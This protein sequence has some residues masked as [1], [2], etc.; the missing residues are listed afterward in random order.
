MTDLTRFKIAIIGLALLAGATSAGAQTAPPPP[1]PTPFAEALRKAADDLF[2]KAAVSGDKINLVIDPLIDA[3]SGAQSTATRSMQATLMELVRTSY[4]RFTVLPFASEAL[5]SKPVVLVGTFTAVNNQGVADGP[6]DAYRIC[7][8][9]A[10]LKSNSVVSKG[11]SRAR[12]E[13]VDTTPTP[14]YLSLIHI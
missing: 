13:G 1:T 9:L 12:T 4:P 7:L 3:A 14:Y 11:V 6:R 2:S 5:A 8:T 10:D